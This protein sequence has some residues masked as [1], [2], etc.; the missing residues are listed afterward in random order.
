M[1]STS[2]DDMTPDARAAAVR[3]IEAASQ[4]GIELKVVSTLR[5]CAEQNDIYAQGRTKPGRVV[6][7]APGCRSWHVF[8]RALD[9][10][11]R[12][13]D[14][15]LQL[16]ADPRYEVLGDIATDLGFVW[17]GK[18]GDA[19]HFEFHPGIRIEDLCPDPSDCEMAVARYGSHGNYYIPDD[20][21]KTTAEEAAGI[22]VKEVVVS[23]LIGAVVFQTVAFAVKRFGE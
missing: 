17:G 7:N 12:N 8:G 19:G 22:S 2:L 3:F 1:A 6:S 23:A 18:W 11:I 9:V 13:S 15:T 5:T 20:I 21:A 16:D 10:L 4:N 14:G